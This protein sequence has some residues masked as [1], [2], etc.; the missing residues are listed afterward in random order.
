MSTATLN[1]NARSESAADHGRFRHLARPA[2]Q[3]EFLNAAGVSRRRYD[4]IVR[5]YQVLIEQVAG[6]I[7]SR[8]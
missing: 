7:K 3:E 5:K 1:R 4:Q 2:T 8:K 6:D